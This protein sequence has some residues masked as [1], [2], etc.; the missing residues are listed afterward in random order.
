LAEVVVDAG[1][2]PVIFQCLQSGDY[3]LIKSAATCIREIS[4]KTAELA[5]LIANDGGIDALVSYIS[6]CK[7]SVRLPGIMTLG[8]IAIFEDSLARTVI[9]SRGISPLK[10]ALINEP[11][12]IIKSAAAWSLGQIGKHS[13]D[14]AKHMAD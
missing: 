8:Y 14:H 11:D 12:D 7:G 1:V 13:P 3:G 9:E 2:F 10:D 4:R 5:K 6:R